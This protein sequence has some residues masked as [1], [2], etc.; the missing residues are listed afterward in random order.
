M[1]DKF[2]L[3]CLRLTAKSNVGRFL[4]L[5]RTRIS[6]K[7]QAALPIAISAIVLFP[8]FA[9][10]F[11]VNPPRIDDGAYEVGQTPVSRQATPLKQTDAITHALDELDSPV[12]KNR[13]KAIQQLVK[14]GE[15]AIEALAIRSLDCTP[16]TAYRIRKILEEISIRG[17]EPV[18][19]K[20]IAILQIRFRSG[21]KSA[22]MRDSFAKLEARW[23]SNRKKL[24]IKDLRELG[25]VIEDPLEDLAEDMQQI[26]GF[27]NEILIFNNQPVAFPRS[28]P[29]IDQLDTVP[30]DQA[31][32]RKYRQLPTK[33]ELREQITKIVNADIATNRELVF[34]K[35]KKTSPSK[36]EN[37]SNELLA[38]QNR[39]QFEQMRFQQF[40]I[41]RRQINLNG[42]LLGQPFGNPSIGL[43][44]TFGRQWTGK[45]SDFSALD[46]LG[47]IDSISFIG[48]EISDDLLSD[49][50]K[51]TAMSK[52]SFDS[53]DIEADNI[54][55]KRWGNLISLELKNTAPELRLIRAFASIKS[56][57]SLEF[58]DCKI[59]DDTLQ[60]IGDY[61]NIRSIMFKD[62]EVDAVA[63]KSIEL[64]KNIKYL[65]LVAC[66]FP[67]KSFRQLRKSR[68]DIKID[69]SGQAFF[70]VRGTPVGIGRPMVIG[71]D[72]NIVP[73]D[74]SQSGG[75]LISDVIAQSG[76]ARA[77]IATG[78]IIE[79]ING[80]TIVQFEDLRLQIAQCRA[81]DKLQVGILRNGEAIEL[82]VELGDADS[83]PPN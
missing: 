18:F 37:P 42:N 48:Q 44:V 31:S 53:C 41:Q 55:N 12:F 76:A 35:T 14:L 62:T 66:K 45:S 22:A 67:V 77:G 52:L 26:A 71:P 80:E 51:I 1:P 13:E 78:D 73:T 49:I 28:P 30:T 4:A 56:L 82:E 2:F 24:A 68:P 70:G 46:E 7:P 3:L 33:A 61:K 81:G 50:S 74:H 10:S 58:T 64:L 79:F 60:S 15:P 65:N 36:L 29:E 40:Q 16:E 69:F 11:V 72:G 19:L 47:K 20:S 83:A 6:T 25:A 63:L 75:A 5:L 57:I 34:K 17:E 9:F 39:I 32:D 43:D 38:E 54:S 27:Q 59:V 21:M 8:G 23:K